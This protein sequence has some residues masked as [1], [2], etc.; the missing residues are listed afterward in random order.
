MYEVL[1]VVAGIV[2]AGGLLLWG[3]AEQLARGISSLVFALVVGFIAASVSGEISESWVFVLLDAAFCLAAVAVGFWL[4]P[5]LGPG[6]DRR[7]L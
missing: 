1:P 6:A 7:S 5:K 3:P 4:L 2:F